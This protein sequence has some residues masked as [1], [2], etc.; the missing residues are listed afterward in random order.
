[1][2]VSEVQRFIDLHEMLHREARVV[3]SVSGGADSMALLSVLHDLASAYRLTLFVAHVNHQ[4]RDQEATRDATF[5]ESYVDRLGLPF[6]KLEVDV[7][8]LKRRTGMSSQQAARQLRYG[9]LL[10]PAGY[11]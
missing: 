10:S 5:V 1:M 6:H 9:A 7:R 8:F 3:V 11:A 4:L 2:L